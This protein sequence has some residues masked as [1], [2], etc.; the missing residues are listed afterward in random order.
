VSEAAS[1]IV[2]FGGGGTLRLRF[3]VDPS[4]GLEI[5]ATDHGPGIPDL[6]QARLDGVSEGSRRSDGGDPRRFGGLGLGLG[7]IQRLTDEL[8][9]D[10]GPRGTRIVARKRCRSAVRR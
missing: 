4:A 6:D 7:T 5:E 9:I 2:K 8:I 1:N 3:V 10:T